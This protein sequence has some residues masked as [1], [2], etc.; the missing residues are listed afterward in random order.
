[1][2]MLSQVICANEQQVAAKVMDGEAILINLSTGAYYSI[3][4]SGGFIW[5]LIERRLSIRD[6]SRAV[7]QHYEVALSQAE[8]DVL[9]LSA[10]LRAEGL[11]SVAANDV[12][13]GIAPAAA[14]TRL[15]YES[16]ALE[17][18]TDMAEMFALDPPLPGL[19]YSATDK[20]G[21]GS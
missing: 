1:M 16:P 11:V 21:T 8:T 4:S 18:Y 7:A 9:R 5:S 6:I 17:K 12:V 2:H 10:E 3:G 13:A 15:P 14:G 19:S 20:P